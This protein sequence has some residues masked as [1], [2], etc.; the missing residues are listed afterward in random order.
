MKN[1]VIPNNIDIAAANIH[2]FIDQIEANMSELPAVN[3]PLNHIFTPGLYMREVEIPAESYVTSKI[4]KTDHPFIVL[5]GRLTVWTE[6]GGQQ[7]IQAPYV[8]ITKAGTRRL[9]YAHDK[10]VWMT[11]HV[12]EDNETDLEKIEERIIEPHINQLIME[13]TELQ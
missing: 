5:E 3:C 6:S 1:P 2:D 10:V 4:H 7:E 13:R 9:A 8:G 12:N 11:I